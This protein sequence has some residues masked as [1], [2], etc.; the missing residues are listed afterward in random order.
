M[1]LRAGFRVP[2]PQQ[3]IGCTHYI[4]TEPSPHQLFGGLGYAFLV[5]QWAT[6]LLE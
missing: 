5:E 2:A 3:E 1:F 6:A 4:G